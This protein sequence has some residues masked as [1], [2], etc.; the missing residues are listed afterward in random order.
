MLNEL[1]KIERKELRLHQHND[2]FE[3][4]IIKVLII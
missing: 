4:D 2:N 3:K 1:I